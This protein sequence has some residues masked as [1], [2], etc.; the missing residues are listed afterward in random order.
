MH[1]FTRVLSPIL[2]AGAMITCAHA[3][4]PPVR[5]QLDVNLFKDGHQIAMGSTIIADEISGKIPFVVSSGTHV[6]Y[7]TCSKVGNT[8]TLKSEDLFVGRAMVI[9]PVEIDGTRAKLSVSVQDTEFAGKH[10]SGPS[11]CRS[12]TVDSKGL[13]V[14]NI[15][16]DI[17]DGQTV[18]VPLGDAHYRLVLKL[19]DVNL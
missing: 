17:A 8:T 5:Q 9:S 10:E 11:D 16:V 15:N 3:Q 12:E 2:A 13:K 4:T 19:H 6:G 1:R 18:E 7:G 14:A